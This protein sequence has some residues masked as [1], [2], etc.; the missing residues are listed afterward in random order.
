[1]TSSFMRDYEPGNSAVS[2]IAWGDVPPANR[3]A[4]QDLLLA[5]VRDVLVP[6]W[7]I[8]CTSL[9]SHPCWPYHVDVVV[10]LRSAA[11]VFQMEM[12]PEAVNGQ[13]VPAKLGGMLE[14]AH[15]LSRAAERWTESFR[16]CADDELHR[17]VASTE[18]DPG[19][20]ESAMW[21][22]AVMRMAARAWN[23]ALPE[24]ERALEPW[25]V[26][27]AVGAGL[28]ATDTIFEALNSVHD[29]EARSPDGGDPS[30]PDTGEDQ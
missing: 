13:L 10:G 7:P 26:V 25:E 29:R 18:L 14:W 4:D 28:K 9:I 19:A 30:S 24:P 23:R 12:Y 21:A 1:M 22:A 8:Q 20:S 3:S 5:W 27:K 2:A 16:L 6:G 15:E 17:P 11:S